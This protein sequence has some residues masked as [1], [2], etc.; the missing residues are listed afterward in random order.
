MGPLQFDVVQYRLKSEYNAESRLESVSYTLLRWVRLKKADAWSD[1]HIN[2]PSGVTLARDEH[3]RPVVL[4][5]DI[6]AERIFLSRNE[7]KVEL[8]SELFEKAA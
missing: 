8:A 2:V 1:S 5:A 6:W 3:D 7:G 4:C